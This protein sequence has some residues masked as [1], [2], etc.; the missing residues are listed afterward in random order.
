MRTGFEK[1]YDHGVVDVGERI[2]YTLAMTLHKEAGY[3]EQRI[4]A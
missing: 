2:G 1:V 3:D 4:K